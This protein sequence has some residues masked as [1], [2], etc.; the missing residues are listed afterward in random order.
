VPEEWELEFRSCTAWQPFQIYATDHY[1]TFRKQF[2]MVHPAAPLK[3]DALKLKIKP[4]PGKL[5][6]IQSIRID[7]TR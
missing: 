3:C 6:G 2:N 7:Y 4:N 5:A 1:S